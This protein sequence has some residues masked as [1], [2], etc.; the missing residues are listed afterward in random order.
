MQQNGQIDLFNVIGRQ[1]VRM[2]ELVMRLNAEL[3]HKAEIVKE[4]EELKKK[5]EELQPKLVV[6]QQDKKKE[7]GKADGK[8][9]SH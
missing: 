2:E 9:V 1:Q 5:I 8:A 7:E 4:N 3:Q 6:V